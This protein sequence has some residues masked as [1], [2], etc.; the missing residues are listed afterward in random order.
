MVRLRNWF[1]LALPLFL[2]AACSDDGSAPSGDGGDGSQEIEAALLLPGVKNDLAW[3]QSAY[4]GMQNVTQQQDVGFEFTE[5]IGYA[6]EDAARFARLYAEEGSDL[7]VAHNSGYRDGILEVA[8]EFPDV[9]FLYQDD[10]TVETAENVAGYNMEIWQGAYLAGIVAGATSESG[11]L[12]GVGGMAIPFCFAY[13]NAFLDGARTVNP[14]AEISTVYLG[15]WADIAGA[16]ASA[17]TLADRGADVFIACGDG[18]ARGVIEAVSARNLRTFGYM[19]TM[20]VLAPYNIFGSIVWDA[21]SSYEMVLDDLQNGD[22]RPGKHYSF[23]LVNET[24]YFEVNPNL[25]GEIGEEHLAAVEDAQAAAASGE[26]E[27]EFNGE[28][29]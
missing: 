9:N 11:Q 5:Q 3:N 2:L 1:A 23:D 26:L 29:I 19:H 20:D 18:P 24:I 15:D 16:K 8:A 12:G 4:E 28:E 25:A 27:I 13:F 10:G 17:E 6:A 22:F 7:V 14:D 21:A